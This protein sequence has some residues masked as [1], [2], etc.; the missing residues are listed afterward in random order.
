[1]VAQAL[2]DILVCPESKQEL[3]PAEPGLLARLNGRMA[4]GT[5]INR[6]GEQVKESLEEGLVREDGRL[7]FPVRQNI[8]IMLIE[9][10]IPLVD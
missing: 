10:A 2:L 9:E 8:P 1:M 4:A 6:G 3:R 5:L 7:L